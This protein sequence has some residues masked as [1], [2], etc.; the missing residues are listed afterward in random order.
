M[1]PQ[2]MRTKS[3]H[4]GEADMKK[5]ILLVIS[6]PSGSGKGTVIKRLMELDGDFVYSVSA[7]TRAPRVGEV[8]GVNYYFINREEFEGRIASDMMLEHAEYCGNY[9]GTPKKEVYDSLAAGKNVILEIEV[10]G[11]MQIKEKCPDALM[12]MIAPPD[13]QTL[14]RRLRGRGDDVPDEVI[15]NRLETSK[16]ELAK[17]SEY[18]YIVVNGDGMIDEAAKTIIN[19]VNAEK[20]RVSRAEEFVNSFF[21]R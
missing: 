9:Y 16:A 14:E 21:G 10:A 8:D 18:D 15:T 13:Y 3:C 11:A 20:Y 1:K 6:G 17:L 19:I 12:L 5:G 4:K 2:R 7:T